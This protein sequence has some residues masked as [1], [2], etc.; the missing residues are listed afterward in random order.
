MRTSQSPLVRTLVLFSILTVIF[1]FF[2]PTLHNRF[3]PTW[4]DSESLTENVYVHSLTANHLKAIFSTAAF[5]AYLPL[6]YI[7]LTL[8]SYSLEYKFFGLNPFIYHLDNLL[9]HLAVTAL[10]MLFIRQIGLSFGA[11]VWACLLFGLH[12]MHVESVAW[13]TERKDVLY[14]FFYMLALCTYIDYIRYP[15]KVSY[16]LTILWGLLSVL[17]KPMALSLPLIL[18]LCDWW[19]KRR[20]NGRV[21]LEKMPFILY[22]AGA[23]WITYTKYMRPVHTEW[24][25]KILIWVWSFVFYVEKFIFPA[26]LLPHYVLPQPVLYFHPAYLSAG[27]LL[28]IFL[29]TLVRFYRNRLFIF[30]WLFYFLSIFFLIRYENVILVGNLSIVADRFMYLPSVGFCILFGVCVEKLLIYSHM[31]ALWTRNISLAGIGVLF[32][33]LGTD[34]FMQCKTWKN[35][36]T[37]WSDVIEKSPNDPLGFVNRALGYKALGQYDLAIADDTKAIGMDPGYYI[38]SRH[39]KNEMTRS[40]D[41]TNLALANNPLLVIAYRNRGFVYKEMG[42]DTL[43]MKDFNKVMEINPQD[44]EVKAAAAELSRIPY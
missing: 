37:L 16:G 39:P 21:F 20:W 29:Y 1:L 9:L 2:L 10:L 11:A 12:P 25:Q 41:D 6:P 13:V 33:I 5:K 40:I 24:H 8:F 26:V 38:S 18:L 32:I 23:C 3:V 34:T 15:N 42:K 44:T 36:I 17:S 43:A 4:D 7:P 30:A 19:C 28:L 31:R 35:D 27:A 22:M 14:A